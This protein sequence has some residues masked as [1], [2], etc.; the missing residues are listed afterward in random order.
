MKSSYQKYKPFHFV[1]LPKKLGDDAMK[2]GRK[3]QMPLTAVVRE[4]V[5]EYLERAKR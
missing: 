5:R 3:R 1:R 4:A 2:V